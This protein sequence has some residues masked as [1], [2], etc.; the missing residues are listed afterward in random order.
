MADVDEK[1]RAERLAAGKKKVGYRP[2]QPFC[3]AL[4]Y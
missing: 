4:E 1:K 2:S 3:D